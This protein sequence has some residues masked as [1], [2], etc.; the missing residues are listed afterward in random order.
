[1]RQ[2]CALRECGAGSDSFFRE[3]TIESWRPITPASAK[4]EPSAMER[5][6][7]HVAWICLTEVYGI[8]LS[9]NQFQC[10]DY[11]QFPQK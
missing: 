8:V 5:Y 10:C 3:W 6:T 2:L 1:M 11:M 7:L 4:P 9:R